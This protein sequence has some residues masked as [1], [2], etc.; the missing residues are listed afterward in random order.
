M[1]NLTGENPE[2]IQGW[3]GPHL[4]LFIPR[5]VAF[6]PFIILRKAQ[7]ETVVFPRKGLRL[8]RRFCSAY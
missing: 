2:V 3:R 5:K 6:N 7:M 1:M 4:S 8:L